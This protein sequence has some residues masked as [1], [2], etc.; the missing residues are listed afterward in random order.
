MVF[1]L[2]RAP[3]SLLLAPLLLCSFAPLLLSLF[4]LLLSLFAFRFLS[5]VWLIERSEIRMVAVL[6][7]L[8]S[9][10]VHKQ[11]PIPMASPDHHES[12]FRK[13]YNSIDEESRAFN[14]ETI[15]ATNTR[16]PNGQPACQRVRW[17]PACKFVERNRRAWRTTS[18]TRH[19]SSSIC[20]P[21]D[22][23]CG[24]SRQ[25][26]RTVR[27][28]TGRTP[29]QVPAQATLCL[30][31][32]NSLLSATPRIPAITGT[33]PVA[34]AVKKGIYTEEGDT[35][36]ETGGTCSLS[37]CTVGL[38]H[39]GVVGSKDVGRDIEQALMSASGHQP[40]S[41]AKRINPRFNST[42]LACSPRRAVRTSTTVSLL[43]NTA[44]MRA[45]TIGRR[46]TRGEIFV[47]RGRLR[48]A[49]TRGRRSRSVA[50]SRLQLRI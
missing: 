1:F 17:S 21:N 24:N 9:S 50:A 43:L 8:R 46:R 2:L 14:V 41:I 38:P 31:A 18:T 45:L 7:L 26:S 30:C 33:T 15:R 39:G 44:R 23:G 35:Y 5:H 20:G 48:G 42:R 3:C 29:L 10:P 25:E 12:G 4:S 27:F 13:V 40:M 11:E 36:R 32:S 37:S 19:L 16:G 34:T 49:L 22:A 47:V 28:L 6:T